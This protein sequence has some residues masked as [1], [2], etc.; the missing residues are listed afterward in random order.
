[1]YTTN[2]HT[3]THTESVCALNINSTSLNTMHTPYTK[4]YTTNTCTQKLAPSVAGL[5]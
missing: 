4:I 1:M 3:Y 2:T 5:E